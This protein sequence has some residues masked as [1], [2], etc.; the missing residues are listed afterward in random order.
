MLKKA[1]LFAEKAHEGQRRKSTGEP[2]ITHPIRV[3]DIL[4]EAGF[5][6]EVVCAGYLHDVVE[7][8]NVTLNDIQHAFGNSVANLVAAHTEDKKKSWKER[9][10]HTIDTVKTGS[11]EVKSLIVADKLDNLLSM[12]A[13]YAAKGEEIWKHF[14]AG[15][16]AQQW[17]NQGIVSH[18]NKGLIE[19]P[20]FFTTYE[21][22]SEDFSDFTNQLQLNI[23][24]LGIP[25]IGYCL[26]KDS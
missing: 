8:T 6:D 25:V 14:N 12:E 24:V 13:E 22:P 3:A 17:Y 7:D 15:Y 4:M 1:K 23:D 26:L 16:E 2:Y 5:S 9:K 11:L 21:K 10:Q 18:M 19:R 20:A